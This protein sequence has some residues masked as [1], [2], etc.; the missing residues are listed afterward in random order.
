VPG[1][2]HL[3]H[4]DLTVRRAKHGPWQQW[5]LGD[6][7]RIAGVKEYRDLGKID[8]ASRRPPEQS[9][10]LTLGSRRLSCRHREF[11]PE[12]SG[13]IGASTIETLSLY[14]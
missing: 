1:R 3:G 10:A 4:A 6:G 11:L 7:Y 14:A 5:L 2:D 12:G 8:R 9:H 13:A